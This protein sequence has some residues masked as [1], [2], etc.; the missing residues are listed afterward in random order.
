MNFD[1]Y[2]VI[3]LLQF[4]NQKILKGKLKL[5]KGLNKWIDCVCYAKG[6][7]F[8]YENAVEGQHSF[9]VSSSCSEALSDASQCLQ[10]CDSNGHKQIFDCLR[11][12]TLLDWT[13]HF[14]VALKFFKSR[15]KLKIVHKEFCWNVT[16]GKCAV[17]LILTESEYFIARLD[18]KSASAY[19][20]KVVIKKKISECTLR[21]KSDVCFILD[22][23][24]LECSNGESLEN[25]RTLL[26]DSKEINAQEEIA[27][28]LLSEY[29]PDV[30]N[31]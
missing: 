12:K 2:L 18:S 10:I 31:H 22:S 27:D 25:L 17:I 6:V 28:L 9:M 4:E 15:E 24:V 16:N 14:S 8:T 19:P 3:Q 26:R 21:K 1:E 5:Q 29:C 11:P 23:L 20:I 30:N 7:C 13:S